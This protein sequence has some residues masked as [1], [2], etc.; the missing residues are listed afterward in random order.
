MIPKTYKTPEA[1]KM[2]LEQRLRSPS[3]GGPDLARR[4]Q[5]VVYHRFLARLVTILGDRVIL[6]G[7]LVIEFRIERARM[8]KDID[9][10]LSGSHNEVLDELREAGRLDL[11]DFLSFEVHPDRDHPNIHNEGMRYDG[12]RYRV[13]ARLAGKIYGHAFGV[14]VAFGDPIVG[15]PDRVVAEDVLEFAGISPPVVRLYPTESQ[16][17]EKLHALTMPRPRENSRVRDLPDVALL[18]TGGNI[19]ESRLRNALQQTFEYRNTHAVPI[20]IPNPPD[21]WGPV[22]QRIA[23]ENALPWESIEQLSDAVRRFLDP[24]L[25]ESGNRVWDPERWEWREG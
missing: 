16:I 17:A 7:G 11:G 21:S 14:D 13:E 10:R 22:Y 1:F 19:F 25:A 8:T 18:A 24:V 5:L 2:A 20:G 12:L 3:A 9:L 4:R 6:K 15:E 23:R